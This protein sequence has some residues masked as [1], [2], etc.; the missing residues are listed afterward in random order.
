M[1][2]NL[3]CCESFRNQ[4]TRLISSLKI[5]ESEAAKELWFDIRVKKDA[6]SKSGSATLSSVE[7]EM[8]KPRMAESARGK[9]DLKTSDS[10][11]AIRKRK[12][13]RLTTGK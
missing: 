9:E 7:K 4:I 10:T 3:E 6:K 5:L 8:A 1:H 11:G 2:V 12:S 13:K